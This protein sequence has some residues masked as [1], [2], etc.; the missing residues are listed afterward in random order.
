MMNWD[1]VQEGAGN[2]LKITAE[3]R[4]A[5]ADKLFSYQEIAGFLPLE[6]RRINGNKEYYYEITGKISLGRFL[7]EERFT[8]EQ[9]KYVFRQILEMEEILEE[10][11][12]EG[13]GLLVHENYL[14]IEK[15]SGKIWGIYHGEQTDGDMNA[16]GTLL[17]QIMEHMNQKDRELVFFVYGMHKLTRGAGCTRRDLK[18]YITDEEPVVEKESLR[19]SVPVTKKEQVQVKI[20]KS[21]KIPYLSAGILGIG[22]VIPVVLWLAGV[23]AMPLSGETD[24]VKFTGAAAFFLIVSGYGAWRAFPEKDRPLFVKQEDD[25]CKWQ[26]CLIP[27]RSGEELVPI[28]YFPFLIGKDEL[29]ADTCLRGGG[30]SGIHLEISQDMGAVYAADQESE[31]GTYLNGDRMVPWQKNVLRDGDILSIGTYEYVVELTS[32]EYVM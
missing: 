13:T 30:V 2:Y 25:C 1:M 8:L 23:F 16:V 31:G 26:I 20:P 32:S 29:R 5:F 9:I 18:K 4:D 19:V 7:R 6:I 14:F 22:I 12:L 3:G 28:R 21:K 27:E 24:W 10:Y 15:N 11:L 17:E